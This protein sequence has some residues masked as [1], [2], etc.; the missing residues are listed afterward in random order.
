MVSYRYLGPESGETATAA[1]KMAVVAVVWNFLRKFSA[2][3][4]CGKALP[5]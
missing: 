1:R 2:P 5:E 4:L 3:I